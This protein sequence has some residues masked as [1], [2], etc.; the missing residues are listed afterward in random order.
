MKGLSLFRP[1]RQLLIITGLLASMVSRSPAQ[2][3][4]PPTY[5]LSVAIVAPT[6]GAVFTAPAD[7]QITADLKD[8][9]AYPDK[10]AFYA[11]TNLLVSLIL[12]PIGPSETN[13]LVVPVQ[14]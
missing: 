12:D 2:T 8:Y 1:L 3:G 5:L 4:T 6:N 14:Y 13:G 10:I 7:I 11:G 9:G